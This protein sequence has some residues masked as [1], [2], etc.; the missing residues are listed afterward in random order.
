MAGLQTIQEE[1]AEA[2]LTEALARAA[3]QLDRA[4]TAEQEALG[5]RVRAGARVELLGAITVARAP[6]AA[7]A[8]EA[9][10]SQVQMETGVRADMTPRTQP[11]M[12][13][14]EVVAAA[15][16]PPLED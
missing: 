14:A 6:W 7:R 12:D 16:A 9:T 3:D 1:A 15:V 2:A 11:A 8:A 5:I 10:P 13:Q 4:T